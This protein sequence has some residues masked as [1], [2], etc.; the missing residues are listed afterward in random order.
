MLVTLDPARICPAY[1]SQAHC[2]MKNVK[3][4]AHLVWHREL[5]HARLSAGVQLRLPAAA[6]TQAGP[7]GSGAKAPVSQGCNITPA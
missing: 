4:P 1:P 2:A 3:E 6:V 7:D 5:R